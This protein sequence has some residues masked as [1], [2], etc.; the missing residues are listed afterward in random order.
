MLKSIGH[1]T[2]AGKAAKPHKDFPLFPHATGRWAKKVRGKFHYFGRT[3]DDPDGQAA[4]NLWLDQKDDLLAGRTPRIAGEGLTVRDLCNRFLTVKQ[5]L[6]DTG[7]ITQRY[8][9]ALYANCE[10]M[11]KQFGRNRLVSDLAA[12][13]FEALRASLAKSRGAWALS[14]TIA[15]I[16]S[17][18]KYAYEAGL[19]DQ[20]VRYGPNFKRPSKAML[21]RERASKPTRLFTAS[22]LTAI[23]EAADGQLKAMVLLGI[24]CGLGNADCGQLR[25]HHLDLDGGWLN[26]PRPKTGVDRRCPLWPET[27]KALKAAIRERPTP[28]E[29]AD[30]QAVFV[31]KY[32]R[33]WHQDRDGAS[34]LG[35]EFC[36]LLTELKLRRDGLSFYSLRHTFATEAG[37]SRDQVAVNAIMGHADQ[38]MAAVYRERI[39]D[40]RLIAVTDHVRAWLFPKLTKKNKPR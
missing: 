15:K 6:A 35:H 40:K 38:S 8:F 37:A 23:I 9:E 29:K 13:D 26:Y 10:L 21:R 19:I 28:K 25:R 30:A 34:S 3:A 17:A 20:P 7:E 4:I 33:P 27:V 39:D 36:K 24:N 11:V 14:G 31:T 22:E 1:K 5:S 32:G 12:D 2:A 16:R 18:F